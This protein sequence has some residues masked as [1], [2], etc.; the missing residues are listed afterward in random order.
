MQTKQALLWAVQQIAQLQGAPVDP[1]RLNAS[2]AGVSTSLPAMQQLQ[3]VC[4]HMGLQAPLL[5]ETPDRAHLPLIC[6]APDIG[7]AV[8]VDRDPLGQWVLVH[9]EGQ[10]TVARDALKGR[11]ALL[12]LGHQDDAGKLEPSA[13]QAHPVKR[14]EDQLKQTLRQYRP[15]LIEAALASAFLGLIAMATSMFSMQVYDRVIPTRS[16]YTLVILSLG[17]LLSILIELVMKYARSHLMDYVVVG[18]DSRLSR[19]IFE[20]LLRL[21]VDQ[22]PASVGSLAGQLRGYEQVRSFYTA[23]TLF[24]LIDLP[25]GLLCMAVIVMVASPW[26]AGVPLVLGALAL[27]LGFNI[28]G[29]VARQAVDG[30][31]FSNMKTGRLV[32]AVEGLE[33]IKAGSGGWK[34][35]SR[36]IQV[37]SLTAQ[38]DLRMRGSAE[39][40][41]YMSAALQQISYAALV[42]VGSVLVMQ[43]QM[44]MGS[45][46]ACSILS[47]RIMAPVLSM[48]GLLVQRAHAAAAIQGL[49]KIYQLKT[50]NHGL[51]RPL[52]PLHVN[53]HYE[54][55]DVKFAY[56]DNPPALVVPRLEIHPGERVAILGP[57]GAGKS[58]L[59]RLISGLYHPSE[60]RVLLDGL[61][62]GHISRQVLSQKLGYLQQDHRLFQGSMRENLL[63]GLPDPGDDAIIAALKQTGMDRIVAAHPK[64]LERPIMEGGKGL[65]GG[66][67]Q[68][69][70]FTRLILCNPGILLLDEPTATMD[71]EQERRCLSVL[72]EQ[73]KAGKTLVI[74]THKTSILPLVT[75]LIVVSGSA[76]VLD[77]P[78]DAVLQQ[79]NQRSD[80]QAVS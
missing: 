43:G 7:W 28:R 75:R 8:V 53:G 41:A 68:L 25:L 60:G 5:I 73:A 74:V 26:V 42:V 67:K 4:S 62:L 24:T 59:L 2:L 45:L 55:I 32:E 52:V 6:H 11:V 57:I 40:V 80:A 61:E 3:Q 35:L 47:G 49:E 64:G 38:S 29:K 15:A 31:A 1:L 76:I 17:V 39:G 79:L 10:D 34:F 48:P 23:S 46:I 66:Q 12:R 77:G 58:T 20:Q 71:D 14:F 70:A 50:D 9:A 37:N 56:G 33:T 27:Y 36:W 65:S 21:R 18:V 63:I 16:E 19:E 13:G 22:V 69:L 72:G 51:Q 54:L 44:T 78:R 30:A